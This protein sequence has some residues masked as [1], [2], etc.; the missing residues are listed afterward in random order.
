MSPN[1]GNPTA[2]TGATAES[3]AHRLTRELATCAADEKRAIFEPAWLSALANAVDNCRGYNGRLAERADYQVE[4][5]QDSGHDPEAI[6]EA[7]YAQTHDWIATLFP[8][9][10]PF[11]DVAFFADYRN[12]LTELVA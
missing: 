7:F 4:F 5:W 11:P 8:D 9:D 12:N 10:Y 6:R 3:G 1:T 2:T